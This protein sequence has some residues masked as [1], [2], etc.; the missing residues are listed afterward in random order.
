[1]CLYPD[2]GGFY[3][4]RCQEHGDAIR[5]YQQVL[6]ISPLDAAKRICSYF[7]L[8]YDQRKPKK[9]APSPYKLPSMTA[10]TLAMR[11]TDWREEQVQCLL[12]TERIAKAQM[13]RIESG[14][15][16]S[17]NDIA[18]ALEDHDWEAAF[19]QKCKAQERTA[20]LDSLSL[21]EL[22]SQM[23]EDMHGETP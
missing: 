18:A 19:Q 12:H 5:L 4:F 2:D 23:K 15:I 11:L 8:Y 22:F 7:G 3:C 17:R 13:E 20:I 21:P 6:S 1:M 14:Y 9:Q 10:Q 16:A